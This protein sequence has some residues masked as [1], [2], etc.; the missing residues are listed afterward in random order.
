MTEANDDRLYAEDRPYWATSV[1]P[2]KSLGDVMACL[3]KFGIFNH[4]IRQGQVYGKVAWLIR[5]DYFGR[6][7]RF[8]FR[9]RPCREPDSV[10]SFGGVRRTHKRQAVYQ[11]GRTASHFVKN[12]LAAAEDQP[13]ALFGFV[14]LPGIFHAKELPA[15]AAELDVDELTEA[16]SDLKVTSPFAGGRLAIRGEGGEE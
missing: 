3:A 14:E 8:V 15:T 10:H 5:F 16:L 4:E 13:A 1:H 2:S 11:M 12:V 6:S 9:P 7:H